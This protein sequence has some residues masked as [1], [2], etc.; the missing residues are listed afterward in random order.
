MRLIQIFKSLLLLACIGLASCSSDSESETVEPEKDAILQITSGSSIDFGEII[1]GE[2][3]EASFQI[4]NTGESDLVVSSFTM[5]SYVSL[6]KI[7]ATLTP[8]QSLDVLVSIKPTEVNTYSDIIA[9]VSNAAS[10]ENT[11]TLTGSSRSSIFTGDVNLKSQQEV[12][13]FGS[14]NYTGVFG[15]VFIG[16]DS[17][18]T[19]ITDLGPLNSLT[20][21][22]ENL[23]IR[24][25]KALTSIAEF[26]NFDTLGGNLFISTNGLT[27]ITGF[28]KLTKIS[29]NLDLTG[30]N[31]LTS[32]TGF[33]SL[34]EIGGSL[35]INSNNELQTLDDFTNLIT[36]GTDLFII[37]NSSLT[38][39]NALK[40][41]NATI[42]YLNISYT[43]ALTSLEGL[44]SIT[45]VET[46]EIAGNIALADFQGLG[47][48]TEVS[49]TFTIQN[50]QALINLNGLDKLT[51]I[52]ESFV[53]DN[54]S[55]MINLDGPT[56]LTSLNAALLI[57]GNSNLDDF[58]G[59]SQLI[60]NGA[61]T[62]SSYS[63]TSNKYNPSYEQIQNDGAGGCK[64]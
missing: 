54:N 35:A 8:G 56:T 39:L 33:N 13:D 64:L 2:E 45:T 29:G 21:I 49:G 17:G 6:N 14:K 48:L 25:N 26:E 36:I 58:C 52:G 19:D 41:I 27:A 61:V 5:P 44:E 18:E 51:T 46:L 1:I 38:S 57:T 34:S 12:D 47:N 7:S 42:S 55:S 30:N 31:D 15:N 50:N 43:T 63:V 20:S 22:S 16:V 24:N 4:K 40:N 60:K 62:E 10:G 59:L 11:I 32:F 23:T 9:I 53:I 3:G 28:Q 37:G